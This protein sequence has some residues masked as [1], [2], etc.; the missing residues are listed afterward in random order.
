MPILFL[1]KI[2]RN[3]DYSII[4]N[5]NFLAKF[6]LQVFCI[7]ILFMLPWILYQNFI[8]P[9]GDRLLKWHFAGQIE[10]TI[11]SFNSVIVDSYKNTGLLQWFDGRYKNFLEVVNG[12]IFTE[13]G[14][15]LNGDSI[16][17]GILSHSY[18]NT[19]YSLWFFNP[20]F[21]L[22]LLILSCFFIKIKQPFYPS[23]DF[24]WLFL[25]TLI[26][27]ILWCLLMYIPNST[28]IHQGSYFFWVGCMTISI[29]LAKHLHYVVFLVLCVSNIVIAQMVYFF[30]KTF[31]G[32]AILYYTI[33][34]FIVILLFL[35]AWISIDTSLEDND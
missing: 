1:F 30:D 3:H 35:S 22:T 9:P 13:L 7:F 6:G 20:L 25:V 4:E 19:F 28:V 24:I 16:Q 21:I 33:Y 27:G 17:A 2:F 14:R 31:S 10:P 15:F 23:S 12:N 18:S 8:D 5:T 32:L 34:L 11:K 26:T 29:I